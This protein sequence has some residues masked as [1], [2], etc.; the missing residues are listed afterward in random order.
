[1]PTKGIF[2]PAIGEKSVKLLNI[3]FTAGKN[4]TRNTKKNA[5]RTRNNPNIFLR[6]ISFIMRLLAWGVLIPP[7]IYCLII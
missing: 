7:H 3:V 4:R 5:G 2:F 1:M 6:V